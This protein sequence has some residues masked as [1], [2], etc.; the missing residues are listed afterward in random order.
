MVSLAGQVKDEKKYSACA[1]KVNEMQRLR[2]VRSK[3]NTLFN[4]E[5][6]GPSSSGS[7]GGASSGSSGGS[8]FGGGST[9]H[10]NDSD[11]D[12]LPLSFRRPPRLPKKGKGKNTP[13]KP[14]KVWLSFEIT[15]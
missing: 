2:N 8:S 7:S 13:R 4:N 9:S 5:Q 11:D 12:F 14:K 10:G 3:L 6:P 1:Q 15:K